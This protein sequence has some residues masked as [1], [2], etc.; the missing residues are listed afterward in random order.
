MRLRRN[1]ALLE[2]SGK[3]S[4]T[5]VKLPKMKN[6]P[7]LIVMPVVF[8]VKVLTRGMEV[9]IITKTIDNIKTASP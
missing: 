6:R 2:M 4:M 7:M 9:N 1:L 8:A 5:K 3:S